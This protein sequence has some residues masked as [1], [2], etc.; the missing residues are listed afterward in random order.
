MTAIHWIEPVSGNFNDGD[1]WGGGGVPGAGDD[2]VIDALGTYKVTLNTTEAV[3]SL[4]LD[5][6]GATLFL[7]R[8][9]DLNLGSSLILG[10]CSPPRLAP[11]MAA[12]A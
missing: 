8:Y 5:D 9:A 2:A 7:Q 6:A 12:G 1:D 3:Q 4:I 10:N 11:A